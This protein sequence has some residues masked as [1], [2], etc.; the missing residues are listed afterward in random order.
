MV[1]NNLSPEPQHVTL[2]LAGYRGKMLVDLF[3]G[4]KLEVPASGTWT[5][6]LERYG[7]RWLMVSEKA[8]PGDKE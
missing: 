4:A 2:D 6:A 5:L 8:Y 7:Y 3:T 1:V